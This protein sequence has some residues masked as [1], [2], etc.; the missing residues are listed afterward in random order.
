MVEI[1]TRHQRL[2]RTRT[3]L[4]TISGTI[5]KAACGRFGFLKFPI[6]GIAEE[7]SCNAECHGFA[8]YPGAGLRFY[9]KLQEWLLLGWCLY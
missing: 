8:I 1:V 6:T 3:P 9:S 2:N 4:R 7:S 5:V